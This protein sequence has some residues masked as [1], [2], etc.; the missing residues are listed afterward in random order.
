MTI[1]RAFSCDGVVRPRVIVSVTATADGRVT[2]NRA[3]RLLDQ[4]PGARW[5]AAWPPDIA[6]L[7]AQRT[8]AIERRH[9]PT[10]VLEGSG[11]FVADGDHPIELPDTGTAAGD[12]LVDYLPH[13]SPR[14]FAVVDGRGRVAIEEAPL[15]G[16]VGDFL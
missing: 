5:T 6:G 3:E 10:V 11:A 13:R 1:D 14:W 12:L 15:D 16:V 7:L 9:H 2:L 4:D 8:A